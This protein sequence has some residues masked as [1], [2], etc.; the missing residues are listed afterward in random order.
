M[1]S[2]QR[3][4][5]WWWLIPFA[6]LMTTCAPMAE[7]MAGPATMAD[8]YPALVQPTPTLPPYPWPTITPGPTAPPEPTIPPTE[9]IPPAPTLPP[10]PVVTVV[11]TAAPPVI[12]FPE[13]TTPQPFTLY[14]RDGGVIRSLRSEGEAE[15]SVFLDPVKEFSLYLPPAEVYSR[16][17]ASVSPDGRSMAL[18]LTEEPIPEASIRTPYPSHIYVL[19]LDSWSLRPLIKYGAHPLWSPDGQRLAYVSTETGGLQVIDVT[20]G[21]TKVIFTVDRDNAHNVTNFTWSS[22]S[23]YLAVLDQVYF[24]STTLFVVDVEQEEAPV[25]IIDSTPQEIYGPQWSPVSE[26][27][28]FLQPPTTSGSNLWIISQDGIDNKQ[29]DYEISVAGGPPQWSP[30]GAWIVVS[31][32]AQYEEMTPTYDLWLVDSAGGSLK[33]LT[34]NQMKSGAVPENHAL[35]PVWSPDGTQLVFVN[36]SSDD[37]REV[38]VLSLIDNS[39]RKLLDF[40]DV[41]NTTWVVAP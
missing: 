39:A 13:G 35:N 27:I 31:A 14:W 23:R 1:M 37:S 4:R 29:V 41:L 38:W 2:F 22:D 6:L 17:W 26:R 5:S 3:C 34:Y 30:D 33:R 28:V 32:I 16:S 36:A 19:E 7:P 18:V 9:T 12:P 20:T 21:E 24:E 8:P 10:T 15:S 40:G 25:T 11:P